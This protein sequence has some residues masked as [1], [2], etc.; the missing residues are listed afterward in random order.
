[1]KKDSKITYDSLLAT[2]LSGGLSK[3][4]L[5]ELRKT[6][7]NKETEIFHQERKLIYEVELNSEHVNCFKK[8]QDATDWLIK[9]LSG[10]P[11][12]YW[13]EEAVR[14]R[15]RYIDLDLETYNDYPDHWLEV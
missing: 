8:M 4:E 1:M 7:V 14:L 6:I 10:E 11:E 3:T 12:D 9:E 15:T 13:N 5:S 2:V